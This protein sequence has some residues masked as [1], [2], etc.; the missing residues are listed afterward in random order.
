MKI[1]RNVSLKK[2]NTFKVDVHANTLCTLEAD[3]D[4]SIEKLDKYL[5]NFVV[6]GG[7]SNILFSKDY[8]GT[9][10]LIK[11]KGIEIAK[12][13]ET[14]IWIDVASGEQWDSFV[15]WS[16]DRNLIGLHNLALIPGTVG[17]T[18]IQNV[19]AYGI[20]VGDL[21]TKVTLL[22]I[23]T[24]KELVLKNNECD[25]GYRDSIFKRDLKN[26]VIVK[27]VLFKLEKFKNHIDKKYLQYSGIV[28]KL[29]GKEITPKSIQKAVIDIRNE[30]LPSIQE[31]G[32]CGSTFKNPEISITKYDKISKIFPNLP[33]YD[34]NRKNIVKI[35]AAYILEQLG[36]KNKRVGDVGTWVKHPLIVTNYGQ[37]TPSEI[38][39]FLKEIQ[40]SFEESTGVSLECEI[41]II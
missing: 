7:G 29:K 22:D 19:G 16:I 6:L 34:T 27:R 11:N 38:L 1:E 18:P 13:D 23:S 31:Y 25:F 12:E 41:N 24:R 10:L 39:N 8:D 4:F 9:I 14:Y 37:A 32:S 40:R 33:K 35:P 30:K 21:I 28:E 36:W 20:E 15:N 5:N 17:A 3:K 2:L 26:K